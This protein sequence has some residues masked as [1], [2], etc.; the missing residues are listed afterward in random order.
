MPFQKFPLQ[1]SSPRWSLG[2]GSHAWL[3]RGQIRVCVVS[4]DATEGGRVQGSVLILEPQ[5]QQQQQQRWLAGQ[6]CRDTVALQSQEAS[7]RESTLIN[8]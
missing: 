4:H 8:M 7:G 1:S 6:S 3:F 5:Q 2:K